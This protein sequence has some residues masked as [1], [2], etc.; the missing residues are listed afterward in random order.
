[1]SLGNN[2]SQLLYL[3]RS[4]Y[5][6]P[7]YK[8][9]IHS[10]FFTPRSRSGH[11]ANNLALSGYPVSIAANL[12]PCSRTHTDCVQATGSSMLLPTSPKS[13]IYPCPESNLVYLSAWSSLLPHTP[14]PSQ[15]ASNSRLGSWCK[16]KNQQEHI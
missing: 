2:A 14:Q 7:E 8:S 10:I 3:D 9:A 1:M 16:L 5:P 15:L 11:M 12:L 4:W 6:F 13:E